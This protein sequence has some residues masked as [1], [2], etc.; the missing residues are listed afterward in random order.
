MQ[1]VEREISR[2]GDTVVVTY[3][4]PKGAVRGAWQ[5]NEETLAMGITVPWI[6]DHLIKE[7]SDCAILAYIYKHI[8][9]EPCPEDYAK[10]RQ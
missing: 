1:R 3:H 9:V 6:E 4:T 2:E 8:V 5:F 10:M 7:P